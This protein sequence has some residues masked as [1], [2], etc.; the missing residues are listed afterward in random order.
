MYRAVLELILGL[1][2]GNIT[3]ITVVLLSCFTNMRNFQGM[4]GYLLPSSWATTWFSGWSLEPIFVSLQ[5]N[6]SHPTL[7]PRCGKYK[8]LSS[9]RDF[10]ISLL[11]FLRV[12]Y[13][14][15]GS[16]PPFQTWQGIMA[17]HTILL[18]GKASLIFW[19]SSL[20]QITKTFPLIIPRSLPPKYITSTWGGSPNWA[21]NNNGK[22]PS[23]CK[24]WH[25]FHSIVAHL[26]SLNW[27]PTG[28]A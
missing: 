15:F 28:P 10:Q 9:S 3:H 12:L 23:Q 1:H 7:M 24:P 2:M 22:R 26:L 27:E 16:W 25:P 19:K 14:S 18:S 8:F 21:S 20:A 17:D 13:M 5:Y 11:A 4:V 6:V